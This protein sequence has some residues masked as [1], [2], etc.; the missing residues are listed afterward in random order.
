M[1]Q[2]YKPTNVDKMEYLYSHDFDNGLKLMEHSYIGNNFVGA[3]ERLLSPKGNWHR[4]HLVWAGDYMDEGLFLPEGV[5]CE[6]GDGK[7]YVPNLYGYTEEN[8]KNASGHESD[9]NEEY[10][11]RRAKADKATKIFAM[12]LPKAGTILVNWTKGVYLDLTKEEPFENYNGNDWTIH[13]LPIL[14]CSGNGRGGGDFHTD[15]DNEELVG[16]WAGDEISIEYE[17]PE[18]LEQLEPMN[19]RE[20]R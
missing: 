9:W 3:V 19:F 10:D 5:V 12:T 16:S 7:K 4:C 6:D 1:G 17:A 14:T 20:D 15:N 13:P 18:G 8:G 11:V 2:Y